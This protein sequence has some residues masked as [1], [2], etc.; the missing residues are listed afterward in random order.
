MSIGESLLLG[1]ALVV[2]AFAT[3]VNAFSVRSLEKRVAALEERL[4]CGA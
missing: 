1:A 3:V 2:T 4:K